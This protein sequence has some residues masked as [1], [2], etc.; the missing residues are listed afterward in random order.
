MNWFGGPRQ[1]LPMEQL[2]DFG[3]VPFDFLDEMQSACYLQMFQCLGLQEQFRIPDSA[4]LGYSSKALKSYRD[5][6]YH[7]LHHGFGVTQFLFSAYSRT[8]SINSVLPIQVVLAMFVA[9]LVHDVDHPGNN[10]AWEVATKSELAVKYSDTAVLESHH[11]AVGLQIMQDPSCD[12]LRG[13]DAERMEEVRKVYLHC[14]LQTDM[15]MHFGMV[16]AL[17]V[18]TE[19]CGDENRQPFDTQSEAERR[20][21]A[22]VLVHAADISN[23]LLPK[24]ELCQQWAERINKEFLAQYSNEVRAGVE[25]T[26]MWQNLADPLAFYQSQGGFIDFIVSPL[27]MRVLYFF[28]ELQEESRL[29]DSLDSNKDRWATLALEE[30][31]RRDEDKALENGFQEANGH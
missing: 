26:K 9:V 1:S 28:P 16:S 21:L 12:V 22:G 17:K 30:Q 2:L 19:Q 31:R 6:P 10:N 7:N 3:L 4:I 18:L 23:P 25:P 14:I 13:V 20:D 15:A 8:A 27:W 24:F 5:V 11:A 29:Q